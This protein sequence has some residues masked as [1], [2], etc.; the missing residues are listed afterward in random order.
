M[1]LTAFSANLA[2]D[3][4]DCLCLCF[5]M[6]MGMGMEEEVVICIGILF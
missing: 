2:C 3:P 1:S 6:D 5:G 4:P